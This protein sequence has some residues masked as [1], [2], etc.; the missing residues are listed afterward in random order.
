LYCTPLPPP[1]VEL[2]VTGPVPPLGE[3]VTFVPAMIWETP[4]LVPPLFPENGP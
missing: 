1:P 2:I 4:L 3:M